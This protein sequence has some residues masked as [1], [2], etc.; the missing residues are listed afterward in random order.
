M[1]VTPRARASYV[2]TVGWIAHNIEDVTDDI[3]QLAHTP[4]ISLTAHIY[5]VHELDIA[6]D[7]LMALEFKK[8]R[9]KR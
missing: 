1:T 6:R 5:A 3:S 2:N 4:V 7:V 9:R 8:Q